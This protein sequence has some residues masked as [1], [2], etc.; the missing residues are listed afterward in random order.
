LRAIVA[1]TR[2]GD[3]GIRRFAALAVAGALLL[4]ACE[5]GAPKNGAE[6]GADPGEPAPAAPYT[7][8]VLAGSELDDMSELLEEAR[9][10]TG[11]TVQLTPTGTLDGLEAVA[12]GEADRAYDAI[13]FS[14]SRYFVLQPAARAKTGISTTIMSSPVLLGL[15]RSVAHRLGWDTR[16]VTWNDIAAAASKREFTFGMTDPAHSNSGFSAVVAVATALSGSGDALSFPRVERVIP[17][18]R[19]FFAAQALSASTSGELSERYIV[20]AAG[21]AA[22]DR[23][24]DGLL[25]YESELLALNASGRLPEPLTLIYPTDGVISADY[26]LT[27]L[28]S[29][30]DPARAAFKR[31]TDYLRTPPAQQ[32]IT[33]TTYRRPI[34]PNV[35]PA[36]PFG[37]RQLYELPFPATGDVLNRLLVLYRDRLRPPSRTIYVLDVSGSMRGRRLAGLKTA[38]EALSGGDRSLAGQFDRFRGREVVTLVP[39]NGAPIDAATFRVPET[40]GDAELAR[41]RRY[42]AGLQAGGWTAV[43]DALVEAYEVIDGQAATDTEPFTSIVL[44]TDGESNRGR[45]YAD[46]RRVHQR[47]PARLQSVPVFPVLLGEANVTEMR[48]LARLTGGQTF[49]ARKRSLTRAFR[50]I[51]GFQ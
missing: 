4:A 8:R 35:G 7:L 46:F 13:W 29:A 37:N 32:A 36:D 24:V 20:E 30:P 10:A 49:D 45:T 40:D 3:T 15:R 14:S 26:P 41:I 6:T 16:P 2:V 5:F 50:E 48:R 12:A 23:P 25:N 33:K 44:M 22:G 28:A 34:V 1:K 42:G 21:G 27:L 43:Y 47:L 11:V 51:R 19:A 18:L 17:E 31:L 9:K 38:L 39:F